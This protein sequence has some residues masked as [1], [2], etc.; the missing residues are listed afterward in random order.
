MIGAGEY[1][2]GIAGRF[3]DEFD[4]LVCTPV[5]EDLDRCVGVTDHYDRLGADRRSIEIAALGYL[6]I[7][8]NKDP[9]VVEERPHL[10]IEYIF[11]DVHIAV[12]L[13]I[14]NQASRPMLVDRQFVILSSGYQELTNTL[15]QQ[16]EQ[17]SVA[18]A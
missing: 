10:L 11:I 3:T 2:T 13:V 16:R 7:V 8:P 12:Y 6:T 1:L 15:P 5:V 4:A 18:R 9:A 14:S 17:E